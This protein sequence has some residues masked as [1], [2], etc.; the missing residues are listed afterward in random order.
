M[1]LASIWLAGWVTGPFAL[2]LAI[3][4]AGLGLATIARDETAR[5]RAGDRRT[6]SR[7]GKV[8]MAILITVIA[9]AP[10]GLLTGTGWLYI[11]GSTAW[12][13]L[14]IFIIVW[15]L[16]PNSWIRAVQRQLMK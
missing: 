8:F 7:R 9:A 3:L 11:V 5:R 13:L 4:L 14:T 10:I 2:P 15:A 6:L 1:L 16:L 12:S